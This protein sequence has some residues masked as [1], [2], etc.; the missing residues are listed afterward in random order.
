MVY[1]TPKGNMN[2]E[3]SANVLRPIEKKDTEGSTEMEKPKF[4]IE[5]FKQEFV[6]A[7]NAYRERHGVPALVLDSTVYFNPL[8]YCHEFQYAIHFL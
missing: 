6:D 2:G 3:Y 8:F 5:T 7:N 4:S 1:Y